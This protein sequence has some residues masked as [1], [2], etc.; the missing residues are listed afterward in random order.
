MSKKANP[1]VIGGFIVAAIIL[2]V[3]GM[4]VVGGFS[5][6]TRNFHCIAY[7]DESISGLD[8]GAP[9]DFLGVRIGTVEEVWLEFDPQQEQFYRPVKLQLEQKRVQH[10]GLSR[11]RT[12]QT[13]MEDL[14]VKQGLR[15]RLVNQSMLT[16]KLK[17][18]L[19]Y[20][21]NQPIQRMNRDD[22]IWEMP[23]LPSPLKQ[24]TR[25]I[26]QLPLAD[27]VQDIHRSLQGLANLLESKDTQQT[28]ANLN[29]ALVRLGNLLDSLETE[30]EPIA[31]HGGALL[32]EATGTLSD[33][34][35]MLAK[36]DGSVEP[37]LS[38]L[39]STADQIAAMLE[40]SSAERGEWA[41]LITD[42][43]STSRSF[44]R[45]VDYLEQHPEA[46]IRGK[47]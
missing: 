28:M 17:V 37:F 22:D 21:P 3:G 26:T 20:Y 27:I 1:A 23:T 2:L 24:V 33:L 4:F 5:L 12:L 6:M 35:K 41:D 40:P 7:F 42:I 29:T 16:G 36:V 18:E 38:S 9:V 14:V 44:R 32:E 25:E 46:L 31:K 30:I 47:K 45:L 13:A 19:G 34:K 8:I 11:N 15:A 39:T 43:Q 10:A